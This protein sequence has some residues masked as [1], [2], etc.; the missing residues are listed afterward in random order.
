MRVRLTSFG[1]KNGVPADVSLVLDTRVIRDPAH[2]P[3]TITHLRGTDDS[4]RRWV[5]AHDM[6][7]ILLEH[8]TRLILQ[9]AFEGKQFVHLGI[10]CTSGHH[11]S[12]AIAEALAGELLS[13]D[14]DVTVVHRDFDV[15]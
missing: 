13:L 1:F 4:V 5:L 6:A 3:G 12:V 14:A 2:V 10:G 11:R 9:R 15:K 7:P 8:A